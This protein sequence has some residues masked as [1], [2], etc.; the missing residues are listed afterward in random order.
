MRRLYSSAL[1]LLLTLPA[2][3]MP[4]P[5]DLESVVTRMASIGGNRSPSF[6]PDARR[7]AFISDR[8]GVP[9]VWMVPSEG[10]EP[11]Q[12]TRLEDQVRGV[13]W[14]PDGP[15]LAF[16]VAPGG[17]MNQQVYLLVR[18]AGPAGG[19][20][21]AARSTTS[22]A[23]GAAAAAL[24]ANRRDRRDRRLPL[25]RRVGKVGS[26]VAEPRDREFLRRDAR[27]RGAILPAW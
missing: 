5:D 8:S 21:T 10:G 24:S 14:S 6:S 9:Q 15:W 3:A 25:R 4:V 22:S 7:I 27:R 2:F 26:P 23:S 18:T 19:S 20:P 17:G 16:S 13:E 1:F 12:V 11:R